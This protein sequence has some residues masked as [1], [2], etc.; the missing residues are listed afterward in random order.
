MAIAE[1][2]AS[3]RSTR[4]AATR[5]AL[6]LAAIT[7]A[8]ALLGMPCGFI[9]AAITPRVTVVVTGHGVATV[10]NPETNAFIAADGWF[11][12]VGVIAGL[13]AGVAG[14]LIVVRRH[15]AVAVVGLILG[16]L[17]ASLLEWWIGTAIGRAPFRKALFLS[18]QGAILHAPL[19]LR[20]HGALVVLPLTAVL[21][22]G[23]AELF[24]G[25]LRGTQTVT[26]PGGERDRSGAA[27][28]LGG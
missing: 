19:V 4:R 2:P 27:P 13:L 11:C 23:L 9:W 8:A 1:T 12:V 26:P 25:Q 21:V 5:I 28:K 10:V 24:A 14:Y 15:G 6:M 17:A 18:H 22:T 3:G 20:A 16:G 7:A